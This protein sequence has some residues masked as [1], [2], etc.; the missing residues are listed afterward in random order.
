[1]S[2]FVWELRVP[3]GI[4]LRIGLLGPI[5][6]IGLILAVIVSARGLVESKRDK[7]EGGAKVETVEVDEKTRAIFLSLC[8]LCYTG[9]L[10]YFI[11][12]S[13]KKERKR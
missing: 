5:L 8:F 4:V 3:G 7:K 1:M 10:C 9:L 13:R 2:R 12:K 11:L 6:A